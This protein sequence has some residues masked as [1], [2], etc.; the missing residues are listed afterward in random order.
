[1]LYLDYETNFVVDKD[2]QRMN[3][4]G[5]AKLLG[6]SSRTAISIMNSLE[7]KNVIKRE[8][9]GTNTHVHL[10][11]K[12]MNRNR[13]GHMVK[14]SCIREKSFTIKNR[15]NPSKIKGFPLLFAYISSL[16]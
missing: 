10:N 8:V 14:F 7:G 6:M 11:P 13:N 12:Y 4:S 5:I 9:A 2:K 15:V 1:M 3:M 16:S